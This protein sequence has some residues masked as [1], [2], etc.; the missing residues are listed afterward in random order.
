MMDMRTEYA[1]PDTGEKGSYIYHVTECHKLWQESFQSRQNALAYFCSSIGMSLEDFKEQTE[2]AILFHDAGKL[3]P[4]FQQQMQRLVAYQPTDRSLNFRHELASAL[5]LFVMEQERLQ[6]EATLIPCELLAVLGHHK[7]LQV[8]W[9]SFEREMSRKESPGLQAEEIKRV[10]EVAAQNGLVCS[11][12]TFLL[13]KIFTLSQ[14]PSTL[15]RAL[16]QRLEETNLKKI[17]A[18]E[19]QEIRL[20]YALIKGLLMDCDWLA[21]EKDKDKRLPI[22]HQM[23]S[24]ILWGKI[25]VKVEQDG[26]VFEKRLFHLI[27]EKTQGNLLA[28]APTG[29]GKT[30]AALLWATNGE[31]AKIIF[32]MPTMVTSNSLYRRMSNNYFQ[33][34]E[35]GLIH[36]GADTYFAQQNDGEQD[37]TSQDLRWELIRYRAFM[38]PVMV[39][40]V[41]QVL[42]SG[43][44][45]GAWCQKEWAL[46]GSRVIFD[47]VHAYQFYTLGLITAAIEK[48][49]LL[50]G[51]VCLM[52]ATM[53]T[54]LREHFLK[55]LDV[56]APVVAEELMGRK[57]CQWKY[58]EDTIDEMI[59]EI[60]HFLQQGKKVAI[61]FNTVQAAQEAYRQWVKFIDKEKVLCYHSQFIMKD[62]Q[63]K[64]D[65]LLDKDDKGRPINYDLVIATQAIEVSLDISFDVMY[66]ECAPLDSLIQRA[67]RCNRYGREGE[68]FFIVFPASETAL[69]Y[70][71]KSADAVLKKTADIVRENQKKLREDELARLLENVYEGTKLGPDNDEFQKGYRLYAEIATAVNSQGFIFDLPVN[72]Q[73]ATRNFDNYLKI[74]VIPQKFYGE[75]VDLWGKKKY[76]L[77]RLYEVSVGGS[78]LRELKAV[79]NPMSLPIYEIPY[80]KEE[81]ILNSENSFEARCF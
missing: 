73:T 8:D 75:V 25:Q 16:R 9:H 63:E 27:C 41:D 62:R 15:F 80:T 38:A 56:P 53:P 72:E 17:P 24:S 68:Y 2:K 32:L 76:S 60:R 78:H 58:R 71:Y 55:L 66:S 69:E 79:S 7:T 28:I 6:T 31:P 52:S 77:I 14:W 54:F 30:E 33:D 29:S 45:I 18:E 13:T 43:F 36:S 11:F 44:N 64:E 65:A 21:S 42:T 20:V 22:N 57:K 23:S 12:D 67:G 1:K 46:V 3:L 70:V 4:T 81:G 34:K 35:C 59:G 10:L 37:N 74:T 5:F 47:E 51:S 40:T 49:K 48:I 19:R 50:G 39:A 61:V 26:L